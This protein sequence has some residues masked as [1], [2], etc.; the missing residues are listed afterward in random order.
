[1]KAILVACAAIV[2]AGCSTVRMNDGNTVSI[3]HEPYLPAE[4]I[5]QVA[6]KSCQSAGKQDAELVM[7]VPKTNILPAPM[8]RAIS[9]YRC[10]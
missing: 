2:L 3:E 4:D 1:M 7:T 6:V 9:A 10:L 8:T 5:R